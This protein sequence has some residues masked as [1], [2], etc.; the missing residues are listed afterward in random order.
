MDAE[1]ALR[2]IDAFVS[3]GATNFD[4]SLTRCV[5][6][7]DGRPY[8]EKVPGK[9]LTN[10]HFR[11]LHFRIRKILEESERERWSVIIRPCK[12]ST[13]AMI[14]QLDD[15]SA[16]RLESIKPYAFLV[17]RSSPGNYQAWVAVGE[18]NAGEMAR[19][20]QRGVG[21]DTNAS[22][23][24]RIAGSRNWKPHHGPVFPHVE[25][26]YWQSGYRAKW[27]DLESAGLV[28]QRRQRNQHPYHA[29]AECS[30][31]YGL[32]TSGC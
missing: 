25:I 12:E 19:R 14:V 15:L 20:L 31:A 24:G 18:V 7:P 1:Q 9:Q 26:V 32:T 21:A 3:V 23:A 6:G 28:A 16:E 4:L 2:M 29:R 8:D 13:S 5:N 30:M 27:N 17:V 10:A 11:E 22:G